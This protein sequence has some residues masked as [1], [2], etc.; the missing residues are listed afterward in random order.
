MISKNWREKRPVSSSWT[1]RTWSRSKQLQRSSWGAVL[2][3]DSYASG[4][5]RLIQQRTRAT[6]TLQQRVCFSFWGSTVS[7]WR[8]FRGVMR[9]PIEQLTA[10]GYD[11]QFGT[12]VLGHFYF[13]K[14]LLP[15]LLSTAKVAPD[16]HVRIV[17]VSSS[18][19]MFAKLN[20]NTFKDGPA[21][22][23]VGSDMLYMQSKIVSTFSWSLFHDYWNN[24]HTG[25][26]CSSN[27]ACKAPRWWR[28]CLIISK[29]G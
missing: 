17:T 13:T 27:R 16:G 14:L 29:S 11:L 5:T 3:S 25:K 18:G 15:T 4:L 1:L 20:F 8:L 21:R 6:H 19:H 23:A 28:D 22:K 26:R 24:F 10:D 12:N 2:P 7:P 9:P